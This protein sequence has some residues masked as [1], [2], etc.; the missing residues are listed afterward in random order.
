M[1]AK[2]LER[3]VW[4]SAVRVSVPFLCT[5]LA[6]AWLVSAC[7]DGEPG[8]HARTAVRSAPSVPRLGELREDPVI[9]RTRCQ[10]P[11]IPVQVPLADLDSGQL[12]QWFENAPDA[13]G[14]A[15]LGAPTRGW[16]WGGVHLASSE[17]IESVTV[18]YA[19]GTSGAVASIE[20]AA[21]IVRCRFDD[22]PRLHVGSLSRRAGGP[23]YPHRSHQSG[24]DADVGYFYTDGSVWYQRATAENLDVRRS[25]ALIEAFYEGGNVEYLFIDRRVQA[26]LREHAEH[27]SPELMTPLFDGTPQLQP[28]IRHARG[29]DTHLHVR[30]YDPAAKQNAKRLAPHIGPRYLAFRRR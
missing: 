27:V 21:R 29:H 22:S 7:G 15:S 26:L 17:H 20:R 4:W 1:L 6:L 9:R 8:M 18:P 25:W 19:W 11:A 5:S 23:L 13:L 2:R 10:E 30:F 12:A 28:R 14:S 16:L 3:A 24:L